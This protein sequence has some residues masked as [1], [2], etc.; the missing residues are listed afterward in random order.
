MN[1]V[2]RMHAL[3][4]LPLALLPVFVAA[5]VSA[6][7]QQR[8]TGVVRTVS[9]WQKDVDQLQMDILTQRRIELEFQK[10][11]ASLQQKMSAARADSNRQELESQSQ[12]V[13]GRLREANAEQFRLR[14]RLESLCLEVRK[15]AG[16]LGVVTSGAAMRD[17]REDGTTVTKFLEAPVVASVDPGSPADRIGVRAGDLLIEIGGK[18]LLR[19]NVVFADLLRPG[20]R[21]I[22]K[23]QRGNDVMTFQPTI[24]PLPEVTTTPC[25]WVDAGVAYMVAP[26]AAQGP[27]AVRVETTPEGG[28]KYSYAYV[29]PRNDSSRVATTTAA[30]AGGGA[31]FA[32]PMPQMLSGGGMVLAGL[33]L[34]ALS[35]ESSR[36]LG[37]SQGILV[38]QVLP[39]PGREAGLKGGDILV[40]AD[41]LD[42]R[43]IEA[44]RRAIN[45]STDRTVTIV[46]VRDRKKET[47]QLKW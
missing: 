26:M 41:S 47:V 8:D 21:I 3:R 36:V 39:G 6:Q 31:V 42:L 23:L 13:F 4:Q 12:F 10:M 34:V 20:E 43:T 24:E 18:Q 44:L 22:V 33:H 19:D 32:G 7:Q 29:R 25:T 1:T 2:S 40:S 28:Q 46:I 38:N 15:P 45:R 35:S 11:L 27:Y 37:V 17:R 30:T 14:R 16:W 5:P 9:V